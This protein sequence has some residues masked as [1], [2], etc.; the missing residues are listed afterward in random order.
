VF[1]AAEDASGP[2]PVIESGGFF[3]DLGDIASIATPT[4]GIVGFVVKGNVEHRAEIEIEPEDAKDATGDVPVAANEGEIPAVAELL[5]IGRLITD[6]FEARDAA[7]FLVDRNDRFDIAETSEVVDEL[8]ELMRGLDVSAKE[9]KSSGLDVSKEIGACGIEFGA[10]DADED[11][12]TGIVGWHIEGKPD[13]MPS[14]EMISSQKIGLFGGSF[15]PVHHGHLIMAREAVEKLGLER[16]IFIPAKISPHKLERPPA[17]VEV[18]C[19][20]L[21]AAISGEPGF[22]WDSCELDR[23][24]PSFAVDTAFFMQ[25]KFP[26]AE[27]YYFIGEDNL[28][29]LDTWKEIERLKTIVRFVVLSRSH[30]FVDCGF[31]VIARS[32]DISST[33]IRNRIAQG[34]S[35]SYLLPELSCKIIQQRRLYRNERT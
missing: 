20:M 15:D 17:D 28:A 21:E 7:A 24:G 31:P 11:E 23:E 2:Q 5:G 12:L 8:A 26:G 10:G 33:D 9:N 32:I 13:F 6:E 4:Q 3:D 16:M 1:S 30:S 18:R 35:V 27:L 14:V 25:R 19:E 29:A 22:S 34:L